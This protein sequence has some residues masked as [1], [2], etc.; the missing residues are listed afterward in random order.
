MEAS[1]FLQPAGEPCLTFAAGNYKAFDQ[2]KQLLMTRTRRQAAVDHEPGTAD[3]AVVTLLSSI[4]LASGMDAGAELLAAIVAIVHDTLVA[5]AAAPDRDAALEGALELFNPSAGASPLAV[6][7]TTADAMVPRLTRAEMDGVLGQ[8]YLAGMAELD[9]LGA[10]SPAVTLVIDTTGERAA[11]RHL[12]GAFSYIN[13]GQ[14][15]TWERGFKFPSIYDATHQLFVGCHHADYRLK[16]DQK[17]ALRPWVEDLRAKVATVRAAGS[18]VAVIE[19]DRYYFAGEF[20]AASYFGMLDPGAPAREQPRLVV[21]RKFTRGKEDFKWN[22]LMDPAQAEVFTDFLNLSPYTHPALVGQ[23]AT[24]FA[25]GEKGQYQVPYACVAV[26]DEYGRKDP[27]TLAEVRGEARK[28]QAGIEECTAA[29]PAAEAA[30]L[31]HCPKVK[32]KKAVVPGRGRGAKRANFKDAADERLYRECIHLGDALKGWKDKKA[33]LLEALM[34]FAVSLRPGEDPADH[35]ATFLALARDYHE[36]WGIENGF[37]D[38]KHLFL[39]PGR[40]P[41]PTRR[42]FRLL[43]GML[44]YNAWHLQRMREML[45]LYRVPAWNKRP[46]DPR[47]THVRR[48]LE[49]EFGDVRSARSYLIQL[50]AGGIKD[51]IEKGFK[52]L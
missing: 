42:Q 22:Y 21:P 41:K 36:R 14:K 34:F 15:K 46:Y 10:R 23:C 5:V 11:A 33:D 38:V 35:P 40:S 52:S 19:G 7:R 27:R 29:L 30:Y 8:E 3:K 37:R 12:N 1:N 51:L 47:R 16:E 45:E 25:K 2:I 44:L 32:G 6:H 49:Q 4:L 39:R 18:T 50:W 13:V 20:Y 31:A 43:V 17:R 9:A 48:K 26:V 24:A 28:V